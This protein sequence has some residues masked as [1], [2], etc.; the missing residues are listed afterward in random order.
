MYL[1]L[2][3]ISFNVSYN[4]T[5]T[6]SA[7]LYFKNTEELISI[8]RSE[9]IKRLK[10]IGATMKL[11][12]DRRYVWEVISEKYAYLLSATAENAL[13]TSLRPIIL[14]KLG[15]NKLIENGISHLQSSHLF[16]E[17]I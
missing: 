7:A 17:K 2:P 15:T 14:K 10:E 1:G 9:K 3:V 11:I 4:R 6:E 8:I 16:Y 5:T 12:A 13:K